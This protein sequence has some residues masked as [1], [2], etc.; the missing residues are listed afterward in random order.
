[1]LEEGLGAELAASTAEACR[2]WL[3]CGSAS[4]EPDQAAEGNPGGAPVWLVHIADS[5]AHCQPLAALEVSAL[6]LMF[7]DSDLSLFISV[8]QNVAQTGHVY[9]GP[10]LITACCRR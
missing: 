4:S 8:A 6:M 1:M 2:E 3:D 9:W 10:S 7:S 5:A